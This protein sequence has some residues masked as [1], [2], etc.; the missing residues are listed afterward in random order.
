M[1]MNETLFSDSGDMVSLEIGYIVL[2]VS[3]KRSPIG[4][5]FFVQKNI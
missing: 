2:N 5:C 3:K 4:F 1:N